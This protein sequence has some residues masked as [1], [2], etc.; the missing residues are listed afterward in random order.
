MGVDG[1]VALVTGAGSGIGA[2]VAA[3]L[4]AS[5][6]KVAVADIDSAASDRVAA[7]ISRAGDVAIAVTVDVSDVSQVHAAVD[8]VVSAYGRV[9]ICV[10]CAGVIRDAVAIEDTDPDEW[11]LVLDVNTRSQFLVARAVVPHMKRNRHG[12]I[13]NLAS[14]RW[15]GGAGLAAYAASKGAVISLT[16]SLAIELGPFG[17]TANAISPSLVVTPLFLAMPDRERAEVLARVSGQPIPRPA[18]V[19]DVAHVVSFFA[20][21]EAGYITGQN[22]YV[23]GGQELGSSAVT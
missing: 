21:D 2:G 10:N 13:V 7:D 6:A 19:A 4:S 9:D 5:G 16:R 23:G 8:A 22:V 12:R 17:V 14:R 3:A 20:A 15:L 1:R 18:T 11:D